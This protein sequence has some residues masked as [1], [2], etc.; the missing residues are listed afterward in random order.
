MRCSSFDRIRTGVRRCLIVDGFAT[1][2]NYF[3]R[4][5]HILRSTKD[6]YQT[7]LN[8]IALI[9]IKGGFSWPR[10]STGSFAIPAAT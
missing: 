7:L 8:L 5:S 9:S 6:T 10:S 1:F 3:V 2:N 4:H